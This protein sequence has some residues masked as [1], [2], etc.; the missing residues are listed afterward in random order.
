MVDIKERYNLADLTTFKIGG[1]ADYFAMVSSVAELKEALNFAHEKK[2]PVQILGGGSNVL[3]SDA[4]FRGLV[5]QNAIKDLQIEDTG[6]VAA[7][8]GENWD[9]V[10]ARAVERN[11]AGIECLS[12]VPGTVGGAL[13]QNIGAYGQSLS[14]I[15]LEALV[16]EIATGKEL[17]FSA[18]ECKFSY[19]NSFF[20]A[21]P[22]KYVVTEV[23]LMLKPGA[24][25]NISYPDVKK[26][27]ENNP[28]PSLTDVRKAIIKIRA[29]KGYLIMSGFQSYNTA[30][31]FFKN[32]IVD[33]QVFERL[34]PILGDVSVNRY[35]QVGNEYKIAAAF[36]M[37]EAGFGKGFRQ[38]NVGISPK[39]SLSVVNF[40][41][42]KALEVKFFSEK[43][44]QTVLEK[45]SVKLE[46][47]ILYV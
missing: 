45:F 8:A 5:I 24:K 18:S 21:N 19:R 36:L 14:D 37:Q 29:A 11:L 2:L 47:E 13:V 46:E 1:L 39:H 4:G 30:G 22:N 32:P 16:T 42:A 31:S 44:K 38:G 35:W 27:L 41:N 12:G 25:P 6:Y 33:S 43:I 17:I 7:G 9:D 20:K 26:E 10:V 40:G 3:I 28:N 34:K 15:A 23:R